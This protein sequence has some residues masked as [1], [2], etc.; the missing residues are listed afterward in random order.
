MGGTVGGV[1]MRDV[2]IGDP[3]ND[4]LPEVMAV[5]TQDWVSDVSASHIRTY[6][7]TA[8][9]S[10]NLESSDSR[11]GEYWLSVAM[12]DVDFDGQIETV[13]AGQERLASGGPGGALAVVRAVGAGFVR[14]LERY[15]WLSWTWPWSTV[16]ENPDGDLITEFFTGSQRSPAGNAAEIR[17]WNW[18][19]PQKPQDF[20]PQFQRDAS[21]S[22]YSAAA[23]PGTNTLSWSKDYLVGS[24]YRHDRYSP[25]TFDGMVFIVVYGE[26]RAYRLDSTSAWPSFVP[27]AD[28]L[29]GPTARSLAAGAGRVYYGGAA[30]GSPPYG[31]LSSYRSDDGA[32]VWTKGAETFSRQ[33]VWAPPTLAGDRIIVGTAGDNF[34][35]SSPPGQLFAF[36]M[37][38]TIVWTFLTGV[39]VLASPAIAGTR[40]YVRAGTD[41]YSIPL[42]DP[43]GDSIITNP[44]EIDWKFSMGAWGGSRHAVQLVGSP[45]VAGNF[46]YVGSHDGYLYKIPR[47]DPTPGDQTMTM[48]DI[49]TGG[50]WR[51][52]RLGDWVA[53]TPAVS[54]GSV[55][56]GADFTT[57]G[58]L[59]Q[60]ND[61]TG[62]S[63]WRKDFN[64]ISIASP[65]VTPGKVFIM[66]R[67]STGVHSIDAFNTAGTALWS[68][69]VHSGSSG[70]VAGASL[71]LTEGYLFSSNGFQ[72]CSA[73]YT[74][75]TIKFLFA[76]K[77]P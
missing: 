13:V 39:D 70:V 29:L 53:S 56:V 10:F 9:G 12:G 35:P 33:F 32:L 16:I 21:H 7:L 14:E 68:K 6:V 74:G 5:G 75:D 28:D 45:T 18:N 3:D 67:P 61:A 72:D 1:T 49:T 47:I 54:G 55:Y 60:L 69:Q 65:A 73:T 23:A 20:W 30:T 51:S 52:E 2:A 19:V 36:D 58:H 57:S 17:A 4:L 44:G 71:A 11:P 40:V 24:C 42:D 8:A 66:N 43:S 77:D 26:I 76:I 38:G 27:V 37:Q 15:R 64:Q 50:G 46:V 62:L 59:Y 25:I 22:G 41:V 31:V 34:P 48:T 63:V